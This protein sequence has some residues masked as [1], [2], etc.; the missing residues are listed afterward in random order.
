MSE[1]IIEEIYF[2]LPEGEEFSK[3]VLVVK[4]L[5]LCNGDTF[6]VQEDFYRCLY[7]GKC[8]LTKENK[9][10]TIAWL[11]RAIDSIQGGEEWS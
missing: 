10:N 5:N 2:S 3:P 8:L 9:L 4:G 11:E 6:E 1:V 7:D